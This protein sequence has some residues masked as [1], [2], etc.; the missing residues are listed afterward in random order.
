MIS[1]FLGHLI[2][3]I[4]IA[5]V[6]FVMLG[7]LASSPELLIG[8][9]ILIPGILLH[10]KMFDGCI[11]TYWECR[12]KG[13]PFV[14]DSEGEPS[15]FLRGLLASMGLR[16]PALLVDRIVDVVMIVAWVLSAIKIIEYA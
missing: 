13:R 9:L 6:A 5:L 11:L 12:L 7:W 3:G 14:P 4:H 1:S 15:P 10:W 16:P 8:H 2:K